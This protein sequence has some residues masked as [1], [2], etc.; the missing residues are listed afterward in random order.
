MSL[1]DADVKPDSFR[2]RGMIST[3]TQS[4]LQYTLHPLDVRSDDLHAIANNADHICKPVVRHQV[5][6]PFILSL[7]HRLKYTSFALNGFSLTAFRYIRL[8]EKDRC[9]VVIEDKTSIQ[10]YLETISSLAVAIAHEKPVK[11]FHTE[12]IGRD[13]LFAVDE[14]KKLFVIASICRVRGCALA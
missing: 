14:S 12:K 11:R 6:P 5:P 3:P 13:P 4:G 10:V 7:Q 2:L 1:F 8:L 9:L